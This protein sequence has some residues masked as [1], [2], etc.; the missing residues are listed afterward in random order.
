MMSWF[1]SGNR[2]GS[3]DNPTGTTEQN[4]QRRPPDMAGEPIPTVPAHFVGASP[5]DG[6][7]APPS[8]HSSSQ[9]MGS[10]ARRNIKCEIVA[11]YLHRQSAAKLWISDQPGEGVF[12]KRCK[13]SY[14]HSPADL[15][16]D[17][18]GI[19]A[20]ITALNVPV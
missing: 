14:A 2:S 5:T 4:A 16:T 17:S 10:S 13:G 3:A 18:T 1:R 8:L 15:S 9:S 7:S 12:V 19:C 6:N 20:A 11:N